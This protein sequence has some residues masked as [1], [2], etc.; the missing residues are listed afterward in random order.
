MAHQAPLFSSAVDTYEAF[1]PYYDVFTAEYD[2]GSWLDDVDRWVQKHG[3]PGRELLDAAC[4][5]GNSFLPMLARGY[6]VV[7]CDASSAMVD[8]ARSKARGRARVVV[9][10]VRALPWRE[11]FDLVT[12]VDDSINYLLTPHDLVDALASMRAAL[13]P[14]GLIVFD[15]NSLAMYRTNFAGDFTVESDD[16][17]LRWR[18]GVPAG[19]GPGELATAVV[20]VESSSGEYAP[21]CRHVQRHHSIA[22]VREACAVAGLDVVEMRGESGEGLV[23][24][25]D[26]DVHLK[27]VCLARRPG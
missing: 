14:M 21:V 19:M 25:P 8:R 12:C 9:A 13:R 15:F 16:L 24:D 5:T 11:C 18:G 20:E 4:G 26:E 7:A 3:A 22:T 27:V 17:R 6:R 23:T 10:D 1:A 2:Y